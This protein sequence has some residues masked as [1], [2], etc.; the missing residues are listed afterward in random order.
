MLDNPVLSAADL[1]AFL[2]GK[3]PEHMVPSIFIFLEA[4][5]LTPNGKVDRKA[6]PAPQPAESNQSFVAPR[7]PTEELLANIWAQV[8]KIDKF[9]IDGNFFELGGD[10]LTAMRLVARLSQETGENVHVR[11]VFDKPTIRAL[12]AA[13]SDSIGNEQAASK[14]A[15]L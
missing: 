8:L 3:L 10:S 7:T 14:A 12:A 9:S 2:C 1:R 5:P 4:L 6:L 15:G 13:V 11:T